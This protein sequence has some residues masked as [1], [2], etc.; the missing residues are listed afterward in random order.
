MRSQR[1]FCPYANLLRDL[2]DHRYTD[3]DPDGAKS[4]AEFFAVITEEFLQKA[5][6]LRKHRPQ[7]YKQLKSFYNQNTAERVL[8]PAVRN[9]GM[10]GREPS[11]DRSGS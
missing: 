8:Q 6:L 4:L 2:K 11:T 3:L 10:D 1:P 9:D 7:L 5:L